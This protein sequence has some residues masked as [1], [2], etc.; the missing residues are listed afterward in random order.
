M[1]PFVDVAAKSLALGISTG[2]A[3]PGGSM[4]HHPHLP[5]AIVLVPRGK[6]AAGLPV[7]LVDPPHLAPIVLADTSPVHIFHFGHA[8]EASDGTVSFSAV[9]LAPPFNMEYDHRVWLSNFTKAPGR[10]CVYTVDPGAPGR[11]PSLARRQADRAACEF[12]GTN[13]WRHGAA[14][15]FV[16]LMANDRG[17]QRLPFRDVVKADLGDGSGRQVWYS[18]GLVSEPVFVPARRGGGDDDGFVITQMYHP[19]QHRTEI[20]ILDARHIDRGPVCRLR[21]R[22]HF[23]FAFHCTYSPTVCGVEP[24]DLLP[25]RAPGAPEQ[26]PPRPRL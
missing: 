13:P 26:E 8:S 25:A 11:K 1:T 2:L 4:K 21:L 12:P 7:T 14:E 16:Y 22:H 17:E 3:S 24:S 23:P 10:L 6:R 19:R 20:V 9:T 18:E 15:R 5:S